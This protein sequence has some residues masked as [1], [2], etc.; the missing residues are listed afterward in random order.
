AC[1]GAGEAVRL[2]VNR[3]CLVWRYTWSMALLR[4]AAVLIALLTTSLHAQHSSIPARLA[5]WKN[6]DMPFNSAGLS[7][8][9]RRMVDKHVEACRLLDDV[10]WRQSDIAGL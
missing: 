3:K 8:R 1:R 4:N 2:G 5:K 10:Y 9:E 6:V 7:D